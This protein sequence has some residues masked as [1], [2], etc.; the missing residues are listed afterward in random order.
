MEREEEAD[1]F[2]G[3][4]RSLGMGKRREKLTASLFLLMLVEAKRQGKRK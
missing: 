3:E 4:S 1:G 2:D